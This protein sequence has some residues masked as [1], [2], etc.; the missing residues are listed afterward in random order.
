[1]SKPLGY[2]SLSHSNALVKDIAETW[3]DNLQNI[4]DA[5]K[6]WLIAQIASE[7]LTESGYT[8]EPTAEADE[9]WDRLSEL[10]RD[11]QISLLKALIQ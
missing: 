4:T 6:F 7:L 3:G 9:V 2:F 11:E 8:G 1:M 5:E 10:T